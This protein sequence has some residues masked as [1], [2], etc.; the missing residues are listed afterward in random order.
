M[1]ELQDFEYLK[2][3]YEKE[4]LHQVFSIQLDTFPHITGAT[5]SG[6]TFLWEALQKIKYN[7]V[8]DIDSQTFLLP[9]YVDGKRSKKYDEKK[10]QLPAICYFSSHQR[11]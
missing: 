5:V 3:Q 2:H 10:E 9:K 4:N 11:I 7:L 6:H 8:I 1:N